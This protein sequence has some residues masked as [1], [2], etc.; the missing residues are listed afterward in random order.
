MWNLFLQF[1]GTRTIQQL[2]QKWCNEMVYN[3][4]EFSME[5]DVMILEMAKEYSNW[6]TI[7]EKLDTQRSAFNCFQRFVYLQQTQK[8]I[9]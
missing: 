6:D 2:R 4:S 8:E 1:Q 9:T 7:A 5:E 3:T